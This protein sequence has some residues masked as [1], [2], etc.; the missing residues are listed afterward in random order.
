[1]LNYTADSESYGIGEGEYPAYCALYA[2]LPTG[3]DAESLKQSREM[4]GTFTAE[5][6]RH[7]FLTE[8]EF[9]GRRLHA[10]A[11]TVFSDGTVVTANIGCAPFTLKDGRTLG[12]NE[13]FTERDGN[14]L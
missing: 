7:E 5:M 4:R 12:T 6:L 3:F 2:L 11:R 10:V 1:M 14:I 9:D 13:Y 8:P